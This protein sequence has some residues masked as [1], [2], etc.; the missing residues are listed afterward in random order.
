MLLQKSALALL[1]ALVCVGMKDM[2]VNEP[3]RV[4]PLDHPVESSP[5]TSDTIQLANSAQLHAA[6]R[7]PYIEEY[8]AFNS[9][10]F[11]SA[12]A[13]QPVRKMKSTII[14]YE[15]SQADENDLR[16]WTR[17]MIKTH[18]HPNS[19]IESESR[20]E[21]V[22]VLDVD[23]FISY[24]VE[25]KHFPVE[26]LEFLRRADL[27]YGY[28]QIEDELAKIKR[29]MESPHT[30][31]IG[32]ENG[33]DGALMSSGHHARAAPALFFLVSLTPLL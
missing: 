8:L 22:L 7:T 15:D 25:H 27:D 14:S 26:E 28:D 30:I 29:N 3:R 32:G 20:K 17:F 18:K 11:V 23:K 5:T 4:V 21:K 2:P 16:E 24:L 6:L 12:Q 9:L 1:L 33:N 19:P 31:C 10:P 13:V